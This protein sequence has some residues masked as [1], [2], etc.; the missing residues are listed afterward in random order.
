MKKSKR[1]KKTKAKPKSALNPMNAF[2]YKKVGKQIEKY[3]I[4][5]NVHMQHNLR[6]IQ[7]ALRA[8]PNPIISGT[9]FLF[10]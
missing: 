2:I 9:I 6:R 1:K 10:N 5:G 8:Y 4:I 7:K 3:R